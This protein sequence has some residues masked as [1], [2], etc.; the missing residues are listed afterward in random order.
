MHRRAFLAGLAAV[1]ALPQPGGA[2]AKGLTATDKS[3]PVDNAIAR[4]VRER[5]LQLSRS[6]FEPVPERLPPALAAM[7]YD[8]YRD[9]RF[10]PERAVWSGEKLGFTLQFFVASYIY[11]SPVQIFLVENGEIR[12]LSPDR[13][14]FDFGPQESR[15]P[16]NTPLS[17]SGF[18]IHAPLNRPDYYDEMLVFQGA[19]YFRGLGRGHGYGL[20]ARALAINTGTAQPEEFP[21]FRSFWIERP[22]NPHSITV[23]ALLDSPSASGA[24]RFEIEPGSQTVMDV[25]AQIFPRRD[26][27]NV[28]IAPLT[29]MFL[30][31]THDADGPFVFRPAVHDSDGLAVWNGRDERLWR[32]LL[33]P[34]A[35]QISCLQDRG[36]RGFGLVQRERSFDGYQD[37][38]AHYEHRPSAWIEPKG[39]WGE[40]CVELVELPAQAE[41]FDN[42][43][44]FWRPN[45]PLLAGHQYSVGYRLMWCDDAPAGNGYRVGK[46]RIGAGSRPGTVRFVVDFIDARS[47]T[48]LEQVAS[49]GLADAPLKPLP[50]AQCS[51]SAGVVGVPLV[52]RNP[53]TGGIRVTFELTPQNRDGSE[54][55]MNL[56]GGKEWLSEV[57]LFQWRP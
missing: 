2:I 22:K 30:K 55:R 10:R 23:H 33:S 17:F 9:L 52:Q 51:A 21:F 29:S 53:A 13:A 24:C 7:G 27:V 47:S 25:E 8:E 37:L 36:P 5:A 34:S 4:L 56:S 49:I 42:I 3:L 44:A 43:V 20:S 11:R 35:L 28:G 32:P 12:E 6:P 48:P 26:I 18:R 31:D 45:S 54:L 38:E 1:G 40:G 50:Q 15:V 39:V 16:G 46:T 19:S 14:L 41:Y 57:W